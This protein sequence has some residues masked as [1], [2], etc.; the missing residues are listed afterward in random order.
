MSDTSFPLFINLFTL[1][2]RPLPSATDR[3]VC[4]ASLLTILRIASIA[5]VYTLAIFSKIPL[6]GVFEK[7]CLLGHIPKPLIFLFCALRQR[8]HFLG[9]EN[10]ARKFRI[11]KN[12]FHKFSDKLNFA[13]RQKNKTV[14]AFKIM[15]FEKPIRS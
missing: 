9:F 7:I 15:D 5:S 4:P 12:E 10:F 1:F 14:S 11:L 6:S 2:F 8:V 13:K 3:A